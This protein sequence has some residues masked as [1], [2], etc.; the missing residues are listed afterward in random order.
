MQDKGTNQK[1][2]RWKVRQRKVWN[3]NLISNLNSK[4]IAKKPTT[5]AQQHYVHKNYTYIN[6]QI[7]VLFDKVKVISEEEEKEATTVQ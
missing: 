3:T 7:I 1:I 5:T 2:S 6:I 4:I